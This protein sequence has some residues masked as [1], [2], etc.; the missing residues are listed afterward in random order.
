MGGS[1]PDTWV[2]VLTGDMDNAFAPSLWSAEASTQA[3]RP[4]CPAV[5]AAAFL[6]KAF[7]IHALSPNPTIS[8]AAD[9]GTR[10]WFG[11]WPDVSEFCLGGAVAVRATAPRA[12]QHEEISS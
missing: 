9:L 11:R 2:T 6:S 1:I 4:R 8:V 10:S 12:T 5:G 3:C 7:E